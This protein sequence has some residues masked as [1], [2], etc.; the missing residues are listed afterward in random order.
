MCEMFSLFPSLLPPY[1]SPIPLLQSNKAHQVMQF[2]MKCWSPNGH[3]S[4]L[5]SV[6]DVIDEVGKVQR[7]TGNHPILVHCRWVM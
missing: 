7:R 4:N 1:P 2:H 3:C 5:T 6:I